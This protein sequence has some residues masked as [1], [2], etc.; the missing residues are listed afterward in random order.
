MKNKDLK[1]SLDAQVFID[2][3]KKNDLHSCAVATSLKKDKVVLKFIENFCAE[4]NH[5]GKKTVL[6]NNEEKETVSDEFMLCYAPHPHLVLEDYNTCKNCDT[7]L[8]IE[9]YGDTQHYRF[10]EMIVFL[11]E[12]DIS[13]LGVIALKN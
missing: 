1:V 13:C 7:V 6:V 2:L 8:L 5:L 4:L 9:K 3:C 10:E 11:K 12:H